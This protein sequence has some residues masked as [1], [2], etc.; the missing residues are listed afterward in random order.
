MGIFKDVEMTKNEYNE[1]FVVFYTGYLIALWPGAALSQAHRPQALH[2]WLPAPLGVAARNASDCQDGQADDSFAFPPGNGTSTRA[3]TFVVMLTSR[4][5]TESQI[6]PSTTVLHQAFFPPKKSPWVQLLCRAS[7]SFANVLLT[8]VA[9]K[10]IQDDASGTLVGGLKSWKWLHIIC[11]VL[12]FLVTI[13]LIV[14]LP[15]S[16]VDAK[17]LSVEEKVHTID[18]IR[19]NARRNL[20]LD[21]QVVAGQRVLHRRQELALHVGPALSMCEALLTLLAQHPHVFQRA[22]KQHLPTAA[23]HRRRL[24]LYPCPE[25]PVQHCQASL[26]LVFD[27]SLRGYALQDRARRRIYLCHIV[28]SLLCGGHH[29][30]KGS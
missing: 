27:F 3:E 22:S 12:T 16:P 5:Q 21:I 28:H 23:A 26:G 1:L 10:L 20:Q 11:V 14:F 4:M 30:G 6:V 19:K 15:N 9:Y 7:G 13:F 29:H 25:C 18:Q 8:M 17:W 24:R 2:H